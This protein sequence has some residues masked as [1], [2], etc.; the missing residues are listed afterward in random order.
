MDSTQRTSFVLSINV[1]FAIFNSSK[2]AES[3]PVPSVAAVEID[4]DLITVTVVI[5][6]VLNKD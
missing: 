3:L 5:T 2:L 4:K 6:A 1:I